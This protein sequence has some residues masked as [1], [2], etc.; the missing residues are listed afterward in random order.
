MVGS[1]VFARWGGA[2]GAKTAA[3]AAAGAL[4]VTAAAGAGVWWLTRAPELVVVQRSASVSVA[5][6]GAQVSVVGC[7][8]HERALGG[9]YAISGT[10][11]AT[12]SHFI[13]GAWL[14][15]AFNP[16][17][18][19]ATLTAYALC[20]NARPEFQ[21]GLEFAWRAHAFR[22]RLNKVTAV[23]DGASI[24]DLS[25]DGP[26]ADAAG[27]AVSV[28]VCGGGYTLV[29]TEFRAGRILAGRAVAPVPLDGLTPVAAVPG[30]TMT[31]PWRVS[32]NPGTELSSRSFPLP[33]S[34]DVVRKT[35][36]E[37]PQP[38]QANFAV[39]VRPICVRTKAVSIAKVEVPV[40]AGGSADAS[41]RCPKERLVVGGGFLFPAA[42]E[43]G[44]AEAPQRYFGDGWLFASADAPA[45]GE[46]SGRKV[47]EWHVTG[48]NQQKAGALYR[49]SVWVEHS[50]R[51]TLTG[52][53]YFD[54]QPHSG[55]DQQ[56][57]TAAVPAVQPLIASAVCAVIDAEPTE[58]AK[59]ASPTAVVRP[60][61]PPA[62]VVPSP[63][64][65]AAPS[66]PAASESP[67]SSSSPSESPSPSTGPSGSPSASPAPRTP[68]TPRTSGT[69]G[70]PATGSPTRPGTTPPGNS[71]TPQ[72]QA[73]AVS[74]QQPAGG[75]ALRRGCYET[76]AGT[77]RTRPGGQP[78][79]D[80]RHT[81]WQLKGPNGPMVLGSG[82]S[83]SFLVPL[84]PDG[85][86]PLVFTATDPASGLTGS[87]EISVRIVGCLR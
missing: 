53:G 29:G 41:V 19:P 5:A 3:V 40:S 69:P 87:A 68:S 66:V 10:G 21:S 27:N 15:A 44:A 7:L 54:S 75:G 80:A 86:Y 2:V 26:Y 67:S 13:G 32:V 38:P 62:L 25:T 51:E 58:P 84:L 81:S 18:A 83:G 17:D 71:P 30:A 77:A 74:V 85:T 6:G 63:T 42:N 31:A 57:R 37:D 48:V 11:F 79:T 24:H 50:D 72:P 14:A 22:D 23:G 16:G 39:G 1:G 55:D 78:I 61:V 73:P 47:R 46:P 12:S 35:R 52:N 43:G 64:G 8:A 56:L 9:G 76:F 49:N 33:R 20:I 28:P 59:G 34:E 4:A 60:E 70:R 65:S 82:A 36:I 45:A